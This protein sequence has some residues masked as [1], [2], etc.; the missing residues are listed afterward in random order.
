M[1]IWAARAEFA[2]VP[3]LWQILL[4]ALARFTFTTGQVLAVGVTAR[5]VIALTGAIW[6]VLVVSWL[7]WALY[8]R[9][10]L[11]AARVG[12][13]RPRPADEPTTR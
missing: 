13:G 6:G 10:G 8:L 5:G 12:R 11:P 2:P 9:D 7:V 4:E 1:A 3:D